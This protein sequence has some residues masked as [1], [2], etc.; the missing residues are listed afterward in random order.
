MPP[1]DR[2]RRAGQE[3]APLPR[4][5]QEAIDGVVLAALVFGSVALGACLLLGG[6]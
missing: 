5:A 6:A 4:W 3:P 2:S 1:A